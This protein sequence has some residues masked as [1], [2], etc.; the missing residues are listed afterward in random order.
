MKGDLNISE[1]A[2]ATGLTTHTLRYYERIG[3]LSPISRDLA[4]RRRFAAR[5]MDWISFLQ[6][7]RTLGMP[8]GAMCEYASLRR[9]GDSTLRERRELLQ[10]HLDRIRREM[11]LL[12]ESAQ[13]VA[14]KITLYH[15]MEEKRS[16]SSTPKKES[17]NDDRTDK[18]TL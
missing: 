11:A 4:G 18:R 13:I 3:L 15:A 1:V 17:R 16:L 14:D 12:E 10:K 5:D 2:K 7:L 6:R 8:I 9:D